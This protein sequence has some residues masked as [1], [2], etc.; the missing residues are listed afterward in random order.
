[1]GNVTP[2]EKIYKHIQFGFQKIPAL[3]KVYYE[4][5]CVLS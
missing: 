3:L 4:V 5:L 2:L 1:M